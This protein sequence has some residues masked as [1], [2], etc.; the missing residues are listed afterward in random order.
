MES[1]TEP[2][3]EEILELK[4]RAE[5]LALKHAGRPGS[6]LGQRELMKLIGGSAPGEVSG[7]GTPMKVSSWGEAFVSSD[8]FKRI[9]DSGRRGQTYSSGAVEVGTFQTKA[10]TILRERAG[11]RPGPGPAGRSRC[12]RKALR[13]ARRRRPDPE[14]AGNDKLCPL[15]QRG[16]RNVGR[17]RC[18]RGRY[19][20]GV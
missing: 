20:A 8:G 15:H 1:V 16:H 19:Q 18:G 10:G 12:G 5:M 4:Q 17:R 7:D 2:S 14:R 3:L 13:A 11:H 6:E 9:A